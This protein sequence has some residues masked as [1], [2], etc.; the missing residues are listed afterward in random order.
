MS[1]KPSKQKSPT[2]IETDLKKMLDRKKSE[3]EALK[4][5]LHF[6]EKNSGKEKL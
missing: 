3:N 2:D 6:V 4:K 1:K 5:L